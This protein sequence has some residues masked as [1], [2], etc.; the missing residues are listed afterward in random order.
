MIWIVTAP[1]RAWSVIGEVVGA[2][3]VLSGAIELI[4]ILSPRRMASILDVITDTLGTLVGA[5]V[6]SSLITLV[7]RDRGRRAWLRVPTWL[8]AGA[9][10]GAVLAEAAGPLFR[11]EFLPLTGINPIARLRH[12]L[13]L[14]HLAPANANVAIDLVLD[15]FLFAPAGAL[16]MIALREKG[17]DGRKSLLLIMLFATV[18]FAGAEALHGIFAIE[19]VP[20]AVPAH[21]GGVLVGAL[22]ALAL[23]RYQ[24]GDTPSPR[25]LRDVWITYAV[26]LVLWGTRPFIPHI[27]LA[28]ISEQLS[29]SHLVP[30]ASLATR[31]DLSSVMHV[32]R[33]SL[34]FMPAGALLAVWPLSERGGLA[35]L[36]PVV[37]AAIILE[38]SHLVVQGRYFDTT[39]I[40]LAVAGAMVGWLVVRTAGIGMRG[41]TRMRVGK[42]H[43]HGSVDVRYSGS[44]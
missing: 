8:L 44:V 12:A 6:M 10:S 24:R 29:R 23:Y 36:L 22:I 42:N 39:N 1:K 38:L 37:Y 9:Y 2:A 34:L 3:L 28:L 18:A 15:A 32:V 43:G 26:L 41:R 21:V 25:M 4:Q 31:E 5:L 13:Q 7:Y 35:H 27:D 33:Q 30:M 40:M 16:C 17:I 14:S 20:L 11:Q 19:I